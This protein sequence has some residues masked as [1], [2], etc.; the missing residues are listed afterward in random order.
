MVRVRVSKLLGLNFD[1]NP[2]CNFLRAAYARHGETQ[3]TTSLY[4]TLYRRIYIV[5]HQFVA[6]RLNLN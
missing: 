6:Y 1:P 5:L 4:L 3:C 2:N